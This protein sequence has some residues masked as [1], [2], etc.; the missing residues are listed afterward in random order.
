MKIKTFVKPRP[1]WCGYKNSWFLANSRI[2]YDKITTNQIDE[3]EG[4]D[5]MTGKC[6]N[7]SFS[8]STAKILVCNNAK[9][10][11]DLVGQR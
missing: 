10:W 8:I 1:F 4:L 2:S 3:D 7:I 6:H 5:R 9:I 11:F